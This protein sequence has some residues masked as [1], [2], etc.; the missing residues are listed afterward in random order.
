MAENGITLAADFNE[1]PEESKQIDKG[2]DN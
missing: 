2:A 1:E